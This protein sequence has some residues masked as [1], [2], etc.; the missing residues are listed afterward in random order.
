MILKEGITLRRLTLEQIESKINAKSNIMDHSVNLFR[1]KTKQQG[2]IMKRTRPRNVDEIRA[3]NF[4][5]RRS[6]RN[7][8]KEGTVRYDKE[9]RVLL[10]AKY[11]RC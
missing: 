4:L 1:G 2:W 8:Y 6:L 5:A 3:I 9:R 10:L 7:A 11:S